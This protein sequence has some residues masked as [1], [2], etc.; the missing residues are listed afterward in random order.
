MDQREKFEIKIDGNRIMARK[1]QSIAEA[2]LAAGFRV[3]RKTKRNAPRG[4][5]CGI[6]ICYE[7]RMTVNS[8]PNIRT[9]MTPVEPGCDISTQYDGAIKATNEGI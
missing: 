6:G 2:L 7:C 3:F 5:Y 4:L 9:C 1:G 8:I